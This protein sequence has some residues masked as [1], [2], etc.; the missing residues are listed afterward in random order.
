MTRNLIRGDTRY[1][2]TVCLLTELED[3]SDRNRCRRKGILRR[4]LHNLNIPS[5]RNEH[6]EADK[7]PFLIELRG[8]DTADTH[9]GINQTVIVESGEVLDHDSHRSSV[10]RQ[11]EDEYGAP[12]EFVDSRRVYDALH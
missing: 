9:G 1:L 7:L 6:S 3:A 11:E 10:K 2:H 4:R 8:A 12:K 5:I